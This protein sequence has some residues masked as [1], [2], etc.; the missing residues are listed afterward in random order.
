M[1]S[2]A[3][4]FPPPPA[5]TVD[6]SIR[7]HCVVEGVIVKLTLFQ[8]AGSVFKSIVLELQLEQPLGLNRM[9]ALGFPEIATLAIQKL[10][11]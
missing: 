5:P 7:T 3:K 1:S 8:P 10:K 4:S 6:N 2:M 9:V 11:T